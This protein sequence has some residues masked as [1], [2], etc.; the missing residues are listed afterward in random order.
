MLKQYQLW[1]LSETATTGTSPVAV[2][3][4]ATLAA[5]MDKDS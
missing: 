4:S 1:E 2:C 5:T 3:P